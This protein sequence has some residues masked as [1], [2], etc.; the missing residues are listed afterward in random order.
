MA[1][2]E[3]LYTEKYRPQNLNE[4]ILPERVINKFQ[5]GVHQNMLLSGPPGTGKT[6]AAKALVNHF[7]LTYLY[8]NSST[9]TSVDV[10]RNQIKDFCSTISV[11]DNNSFKIVILDEID[12]VSD[13]FFKALR[14]TME[15]F[16]QNSRFIATCNYINKLPDAIISRFEHIDF[17]FDKEEESEL[18][19]KYAKRIYQ[20]CQNEGINID[21]QALVE[22]TKRNFP[23]L[24]ATLN[25]LQGYKTQGT[26]H[27]TEELVKKFNSIYK[28][29]YDLI[30]S[31]ADATQNYQYI[32]SNYS[33]NVDDVLSSL[34]D[35]FIDYIK[36]EK[37][38]Y[39]RFIPQII[40]SVAKHQQ[41]R[42]N[43]ID[44]VISLLSCIFEIQ[45]IINQ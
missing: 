21:K 28:D 40:I 44:P 22:F 30:F 6:S 13:Q 18:K 31:S 36:E 42:N 41:Q 34:G 39:T 32:V 24:R 9:D 17:S 20:I 10:I 38:Y 25:K 27:I 15:Q 33:N 11:M 26:Y 43:V 23:D 2:V 4:L 45:T 12:G 16:S 1:V 8:I 14:A 3:R 35:E 7:E 29:V 19:K 5:T 37:E